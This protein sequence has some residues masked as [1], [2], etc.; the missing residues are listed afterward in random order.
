MKELIRK[1]PDQLVEL[2]IDERGIFLDPD[3]RQLYPTSPEDRLV[4]RLR[5]YRGWCEKNKRSFSFDTLYFEDLPSDLSEVKT[6]AGLI[7]KHVNSYRI[8]LYAVKELAQSSLGRGLMLLDNVI[9]PVLVSE[10]EPIEEPGPRIIYANKA[11][12]K[13]TGHGGKDVIGKNPRI[14]QGIDSSMEARNAIRH[15][16]KSWVPVK[17]EIKNYKKNGE[18]FFTELNISPVSDETG[19]W[20]HWVSFQRDIT[21]ESAQRSSLDKLQEIGRVGYWSLKFSNMETYWSSEVFKIYGIEQGKPLN[22]DEAIMFMAPHERQKVQDYLVDCITNKKK[23][24]DV[25]EFYDAAKVKKW[26]RLVGDPVVE[27]NGE[28]LELCGVIQDVTTEVNLEKAREEEN[29]KSL[30]QSRLASIGELAAGV[31]HEINNPLAIAAGRL[32][33]LK[34]LVAEDEEI[35]K[36]FQIIEK[37]HERIQNITKGLRN[38]SRSDNKKTSFSLSEAIRESVNFI[39]DIY[40]SYGIDVRL[41]FE[42]ENEELN[43]LGNRGE[44]LQVLMNL[45]SNAKDATEGRES[46][47]ITIS[48]RT[49]LNEVEIKVK[50]NGTGIPQDIQDKIFDAFFT[51]KEVGKGTGIGLS[52]VNQIV[53]SMKGKISLESKIGAGTTFKIQLPL[54]NAFQAPVIQPYVATPQLTKTGLKI[55]VVEDEPELAVLIKGMLNKL[56]CEVELSFNG[57]EGHEKLLKNTYDLILSDIQMPK[58]SGIELLKRLRSTPGLHQPKFLFITGGVSEE[59]IHPDSLKLSQGFIKKPFTLSNLADEINKVLG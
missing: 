25:F 8:Q 6:R 37:A 47:E 7:E 10:A 34:D 26:V 24:D 33:F 40:R 30:I 55:L 15:A 58:L 29:R 54:S 43:V 16:L 1:D 18:P 45:L 56:G 32:M 20:T 51:T 31:G 38:F 22:R 17:T 27:P 48:V 53:T 50:D 9:E 57:E 49:N 3:C 35:A 14:L 13:L 46:R 52:L 42:D 12:E 23:F 11:F 5:Y 44:F 36:N 39:K 28:I 59:T 19:W 41:D 21:Q 4:K 2:Y